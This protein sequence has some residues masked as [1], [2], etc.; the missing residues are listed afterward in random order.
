LNLPDFEMPIEYSGIRDEHM[1]VR[2][3]VGV[4]D[5]SHMAANF[6]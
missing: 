4:F 6:G 3:G 5:V 2:E 1:T